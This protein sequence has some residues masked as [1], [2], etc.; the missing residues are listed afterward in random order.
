MITP[1]IVNISGSTVKQTIKV[2]NGQIPNSN[3]FVTLS[4]DPN[5]TIIGSNLGKGALSGNIWTIGNVLANESINAEITYILNTS[6]SGDVEYNFTAIVNA[7]LDNINSNNSITDKVLYKHLSCNSDPCAEP[8]VPVVEITIPLKYEIP[9]SVPAKCD[10][11]KTAFVLGNVENATVDIDPFTG[12]GKIVPIDYRYPYEVEVFT[13]CKTT[14]KTSVFGPH[15]IRGLGV[16]QPSVIASNLEVAGIIAEE[17]TID[18]RLYTTNNDVCETVTW[19]VVSDSTGTAV[20][21]DSLIT[22]TPQD[23]DEIITWR[24]VCADGTTMDE[25]VILISTPP[26]IMDLEDGSNNDIPCMIINS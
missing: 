12:I 2:T 11:G 1:N 19:E 13:H 7:T 15:I 3:A 23:N 10:I 6:P 26:V 16:C 14:C 22:Y 9:F 5:W 24:A 18:L 25:G 21:T 17:N 20:I 8:N 4:I